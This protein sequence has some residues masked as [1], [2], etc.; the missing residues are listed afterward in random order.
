MCY[1]PKLGGFYYVI[2]NSRFDDFQGKKNLE[3]TLA[4][5]RPLVPNIREWQMRD[6]SNIEASKKPQGIKERR[7]INFQVSSWPFQG[8]FLAVKSLGMY[9]DQFKISFFAVVACC[10]KLIPP[11][12]VE[13][14]RRSFRRRSWKSSIV[15]LGWFRPRNS[16]VI[17]Q[18]PIF[19]WGDET[20]C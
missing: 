1:P 20:W 6:L 3:P 17:Q 7:W 14:I 10:F 8:V 9:I 4:P 13:F 11:K 18:L 2:L 15:L 16:G 12:M 5:S 19:V